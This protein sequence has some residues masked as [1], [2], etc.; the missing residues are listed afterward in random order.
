MQRG[1]GRAEVARRREKRNGM[2]KTFFLHVCASRAFCR[3][4]LL[5]EVEREKES[6]LEY[7]I[8]FAR[9]TTLRS[10]MMQS[11]CFFFIFFIHVCG[12]ALAAAPPSPESQPLSLVDP[13]SVLAKTPSSNASS[14]T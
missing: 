1:K 2:G 10:T 13:S 7:R 8:A 14:L 6:Q 11:N 12:Y 3:V 5:T 4:S 9:I